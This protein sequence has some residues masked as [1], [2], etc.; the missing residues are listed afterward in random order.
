MKF[1]MVIAQNV[2]WLRS[3]EDKELVPGDRE[4]SQCGHF[5]QSGRPE[6]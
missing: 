2:A 6:R 3:H 4:W 5:A 1:V